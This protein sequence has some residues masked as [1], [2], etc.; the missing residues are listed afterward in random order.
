[1]CLL[2]MDGVCV[3]VRVCLGVS[4]WHA[5]GHMYVGMHVILQFYLAFVMSLTVEIS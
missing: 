5:G 2:I 4:A 1:M 3:S